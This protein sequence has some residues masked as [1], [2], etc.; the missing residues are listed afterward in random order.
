M[1]L[2]TPT[3]S[4]EVS[5]ALVRRWCH[6]PNPR[7]FSVA[8]CMRLAC[9][10]VRRVRYHNAP[11]NSGGT[12]SSTASPLAPIVATIA[13]PQSISFTSVTSQNACVPQRTN[14]PGD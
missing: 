6:P 3:G 9:L 2:A 1:L 14:D 11:P 12:T 7:S 8:A 5:R 13:A 10:V 4:T